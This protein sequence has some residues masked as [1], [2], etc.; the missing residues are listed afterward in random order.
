MKCGGRRNIEICDRK[1]KQLKGKLQ[2]A[3]VIPDSMFVTRAPIEK[4][5][6]TGSREGLYDGSV[7]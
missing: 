4:R 2:A 3:C 6:V 5:E 7:M 1:I